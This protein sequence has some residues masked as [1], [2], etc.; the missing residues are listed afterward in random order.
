M[1]EP[2]RINVYL[3]YAA[4]IAVE[5]LWIGMI[6]AASFILIFLLAYFVR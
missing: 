6:F 3:R 5:I 1:N 2:S 4:G